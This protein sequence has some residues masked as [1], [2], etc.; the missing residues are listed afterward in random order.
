MRQLFIAVAT[1][2][3]ALALASC[4]PRPLVVQD[5]RELKSITLKV[6]NDNSAWTAGETRIFT[7][8]FEP[9]NAIIKDIQLE[10]N[11]EGMV[12]INPGERPDQFLVMARKA[13]RVKL[14][15]KAFDQNDIMASDELTF[16]ITGDY[17]PKMSV[18][19]RRIGDKTNGKAFPKVMVC[20]SGQ[21]FQIAALSDNNGVQFRMNVIDNGAVSIEESGASVWTLKAKEPG[22][23]RLTVT[24]TDRFGEKREKTYEIYVYGYVSF[25]TKMDFSTLMLGLTATEFDGEEQTGS[26][27]EV[28]GNCY[29]WPSGYTN[30]RKTLSLNSLKDYIVFG[31]GFDNPDML[32]VQ[33]PFEELENLAPYN[34]KH[35]EVHGISVQFHFEIDNPYIIVSE[36]KPVQ[37]EGRDFT[38]RASF[39]QTGLEENYEIEDDEAEEIDMDGISVDG[40]NTIEYTIPL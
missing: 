2:T 35:Y 23:T 9:T 1:A 20:E 7:V 37:P 16:N 10:Q 22:N 18:R 36:V 30:Q 13:G 31:K 5:T 3:A 32:D 28:D 17:K 11:I 14:T 21:E 8:E 33:Y 29:G 6:N 15:A 24:M 40:W 4:D 39:T 38:I 25:E 26:L 27:L 19:I 12:E 34:G